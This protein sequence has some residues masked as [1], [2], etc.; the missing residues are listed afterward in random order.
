MPAHTLFMPDKKALYGCP[1]RVKTRSYLSPSPST[2]LTPLQPFVG[3]WP[4]FQYLNPI[5][6]RQDSLDGGSARRYLH[7][8]Q[9]KHGIKANRYP[10]LAGIRIHDP[11]VQAGK[12]GSC[13]RPRG[14]WSAKATSYGLDDRGVGVR[15]PVG[16]RIFSCPNRPD[17]LWGPPNFLSNGYRGLFPRGK[18]AGAWSRPLTSN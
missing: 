12:D 7:T 14:Q 3:L 15:V 17:R 1:S 16:W 8:E 4:H 9:H 2:P 13:L 10:C 5:H 18:A 11:S 6:S